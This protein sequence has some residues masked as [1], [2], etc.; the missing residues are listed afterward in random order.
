MPNEERSSPDHLEQ[1]SKMIWDATRTL[2]DAQRVLFRAG[3]H[4]VG[5]VW[6]DGVRAII[7]MNERLTE[8]SGELSAID[9]ELRKLVHRDRERDLPPAAGA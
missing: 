7:E 6:G 2:E 1:A 3:D 9:I 8:I 5:Q 4:Y